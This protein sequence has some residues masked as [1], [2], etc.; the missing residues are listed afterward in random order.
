MLFPT[1]ST[2]FFQFNAVFILILVHSI[3]L[4]TIRTGFNDL[5]YSERF[6]D[7]KIDVQSLEKCLS[8]IFSNQNC[9]DGKINVREGV[10]L[11][12]NWLL[13]VYDK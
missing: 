3:D 4:N 1:V 6:S 7:S 10:E 2:Y 12:L 8:E 11:T 13:N 5:G 9:K